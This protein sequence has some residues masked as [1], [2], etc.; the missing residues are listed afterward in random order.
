MDFI[1]E[2]MS[3]FWSLFTLENLG[4][5]ILG[6]FIGVIV[7]ALPGFA[8]GNALAIMLPMT[9]MF[10]PAAA[11]IFM[12]ALY[13]GSAYGGSITAILINTP[14]TPDATVTALDGYPMSQKG[15]ADQ[16]MG[17]SLGA[18]CLGGLLSV[19]MVVLVI[20]PMSRLTMAFGPY[21][22]FAVGIFGLS[23][24]AVILGGDPLK[25]LASGLLGMLFAAMGADPA[26]G[27]PRLTFGIIQLYDTMEFVPAVIGMFA[28]SEFM[29]M[30]NNKQV[31][32]EL[33]ESKKIGNFKNI[34]QGVMMVIK[35]PLAVLRASLIGF[36]VGVIPGMGMTVATFA[37]YGI[38][39]NTDKHP[40]RFGTGVPEGLIA[41][42]G[43]NNAVVSGS[44]VPTFALGIPGS[45]TTAVMMAALM[46]HGI[47]PGPELM[48]QYGFEVYQVFG[49]LFL[50]II[51]MFAIGF[52]LAKWLSKITMIPNNL[53]IP[54]VCVLI[55]LGAYA[56]RQ[57]FFDVILMLFFGL[58]AYMMRKQGYPPVP[59][60]LGLI[61]G[62]TVESN[63]MR[64]L[65]MCR[66]DYWTIF[67]ASPIC[68]VIWL[69]VLASLSLPFILNMK[70]AKKNK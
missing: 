69:A 3:A 57:V 43:C 27:M 29:F 23:I 14:G 31:A 20:Q 67:T 19:V 46:L 7:G 2:L 66:G 52:F 32:S 45:S 47:V 70:K 16:A 12:S 61:I 68:I 1:T 59:L 55:V 38:A 63:M 40:E 42:E 56:C 26:K 33:M 34:L 10:E 48:K 21:E 37:S 18:S 64:V 54:I 41:A 4:F 62:P 28:F 11:L 22:M 25:G 30:M 51:I 13:M 58:L 60:L 53:L 65:K 44:L 15:M 17:V 6:T 49:C 50:A 39:K 24:I 8:S 5:I 35:R 36:V 9:V